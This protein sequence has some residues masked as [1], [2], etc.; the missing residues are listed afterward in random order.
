MLL[1]RLT[2]KAST[3]NVM[4]IPRDLKVDIPGTASRKINAAYSDGGHGL[5]I[6]T[7]SE[8]VPG[9]A[10][11]PHRRHELQRLPRPVD[12][13]AAS[14][15]TSIA[16]TTTT[17]GAGRQQLLEHRHPARL[18]EAVRPGRARLR[19][20]PPPDSDIVRE[21]RQQDFIRWAKDQFGV[22]KLSR[23]PKDSSCGSSASTPR[24]T[25]ACSRPTGSWTCSSWSSTPRPAPDPPGGVP[26][27]P[28]A[29]TASYVTC[30]PATGPVER[31]SSGSW[32]R[33]AQGQRAASQRGERQAGGA[34]AASTA[35]PTGGLEVARA[36]G[37]QAA[38]R[39]PGRAP[40]SAS[41]TFPRLLP[42]SC[43]SARLARTP[44]PT[45]ASTPSATS[46]A[47]PTSPTG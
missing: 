29:L 2:A 5:L 47:G 15:P 46:R 39:D 17:H 42:A 28:A 35:T 27:R 11:Q 43:A 13:S 30:H 32:P 31:P 45:R 23:R 4:S 38:A 10:H 12:A 1:V 36:R 34:Q 22:G 37:R 20:L 44:T 24:W 9:P 41:S 33:G 40:P 21:A 6:K 18:P 8:R 16:A 25:R 3:I 7:I 26:G 19:P 14:T